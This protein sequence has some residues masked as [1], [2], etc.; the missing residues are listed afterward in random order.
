MQRGPYGYYRFICRRHH[1][2]I[3][4]DEEHS[5]YNRSHKG[6]NK[7]FLY[8]IFPPM[9]TLLAMF[10]LYIGIIRSIEKEM[11]TLGA[12]SVNTHALLG[13]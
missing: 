3:E 7:L 5:E 13:S 6:R 4:D 10:G 9:V 12:A 11:K 8:A 2:L 1:G